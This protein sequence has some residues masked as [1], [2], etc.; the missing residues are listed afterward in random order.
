MLMKLPPTGE[1]GG[2]AGESVGPKDAGDGAGTG[3]P[4]AANK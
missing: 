1:E 3:A 4:V 2:A